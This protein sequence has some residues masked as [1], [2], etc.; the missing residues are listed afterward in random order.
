MKVRQACSQ[1]R[2]RKKRCYRV[3]N[4]NACVRCVEGKLQCSYSIKPTRPPQQQRLQPSA[5]SSTTTSPLEL[6][7]DVVES[8]VE[9]YLRYIHDRPHSLFHGPTLRRQV[10]DDRLGK[11]LLCAVCSYGSRFHADA[12]IQ[13][14]ASPLTA[15]AKR[16]LNMDIEN[17]CLENVKTAILVA[18]L[19]AS[20]LNS[21][22][23]AIY[24]SLANRMAYILG[25]N[26]PDPR[27]S[28]VVKETKL[29]VWS[30]L[31][32][33][34]RWCSTRL[35]LPRQISDFDFE[36]RHAPHLPMDESVFHRLGPDEHAMPEPW[37]PGLW[38]HMITLVRVFGPIQDFNQRLAQDGV[39][40]DELDRS[41]EQLA[42]E[43]D[44]WEQLLPVDIKLTRTNL[45]SHRRNGQGGPFVA[46]HLGFHH[47]ST[48]LYFHSLDYPPATAAVAARTSFADRCRAHA[49]ACSTLLQTARETEGCEAVYATVGQMTMVSSAV[50]LHTLLFGNDHEL[51]DARS[52]LT[53]NFEA[54]IELKKYWPVSIGKTIERLFVFQDMCLMSADA[55][56]THKIDRW[57]VRFLLEHSLPLLD[58]IPPEINDAPSSVEFATPSNHDRSFTE[59]GL[60]TKHVLSG[61]LDGDM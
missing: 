53:S 60:I 42:Q 54:L 38:A 34:D 16:I 10:R 25:I 33:S 2:C 43:L 49:S 47:Y 5:W 14:L 46:L 35:G 57:M 23:E 7:K 36:G 55:Q 37:K 32:M 15:E 21:T 24:C 9:L 59:R 13:S 56:S 1:C 30:S 50:L 12:S 6:P 41:V 26:K 27:D 18:N 48:L 58:E 45:E 28:I 19:S 52:S 17:A 4:G 39:M 8:V 29:R 44:L 22:S 40:D 51:A 3:D 11:A 20:E 31:F 61:L